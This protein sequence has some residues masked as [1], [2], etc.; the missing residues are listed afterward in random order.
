VRSA[1]RSVDGL[2]RPAL[3]FVPTCQ[4]R[5]APARRPP[6]AEV[7]RSALRADSAALLGLGARR[8]THCANCV[9]SVRTSSPS[10]TTKRAD[11]RRPQPCAARRLSSSRE[12]RRAVAARGVA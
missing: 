12:G 6:R 8:A 1:V 3:C 5:A 4:P 7:R 9:R 11:A 10:M 2:T